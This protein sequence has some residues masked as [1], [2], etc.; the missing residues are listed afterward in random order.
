MDD[1]ELEKMAADIRSMMLSAENPG[2][3]LRAI[4]RSADVVYGIYPAG[5]GFA[6]LLIKGQHLLDG[7][8]TPKKLTAIPCRDADEAHAFQARF[9]DN[10]KVTEGRSDNKKSDNGKADNN[11]SDNNKADTNKA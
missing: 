10:G 3:T 9:G 4:F 5:E 6:K 1:T 7:H 2:E 11:K 8:H